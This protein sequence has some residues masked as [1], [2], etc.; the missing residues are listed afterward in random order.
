MAEEREDIMHC[1]LPVHSLTPAPGMS[2]QVVPM[3]AV[4]V[5]K[6]EDELEELERH[7]P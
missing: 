1:A 4:W 7:S 5:A 6:P 2:A 3:H